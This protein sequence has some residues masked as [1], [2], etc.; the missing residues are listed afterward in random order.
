MNRKR[1]TIVSKVCLTILM[2][3]F[4]I[5]SILPF[6]WMVS[7]SLKFEADIFTYPVKWI[8]ERF[9]AI[10]NYTEVLTG[11]YNFS[12]FYLNTIKITVLSTVL[13]VF[14]SAMAGYAFAKIDFKF[15]NILF[16]V[17]LSVL[18]IPDQVTLV[19]K[20]LLSRW[21]GL[22]DTHAII[23]ILLSFSAYGTFL[24]R[25]YMV[26]IPIPLSES[27]RIDGA[28]HW[29][30]FTRIILPMSKPIIATLAIIKFVW[31]WNDYQTSLVFLRSRNLF[32]IQLGIQQFTSE[33]GAYYSL[34]MAAAVL[35][36]LPLFIVFLMGQK[37][38]IEGMTAGAVKG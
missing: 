31:T 29:T 22:Y 3:A 30:I 37:Y 21:L 19:P 1:W 13:Q 28:N 18:M 36:I 35:A 4:T 10:E 27:A 14:F 9:N 12:L 5:I 34:Q 32:T 38:I 23:V 16:P 17:F 6:V 2:T 25:Q 15:K 7:S 26:T 20:F 24:M 33:S 8:P 11:K